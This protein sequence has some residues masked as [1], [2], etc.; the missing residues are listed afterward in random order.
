[1]HR[2]FESTF[3]SQQVVYI[4]TNNIDGLMSQYHEDAVLIFLDT[5]VCGRKHIRDFLIQN[6][7]YLTD[8]NL[9]Q[10][11]KYN[12]T[13]GIIFVQ[14]VITLHSGKRRVGY[15]LI[16]LDGK[17]SFQIVTTVADFGIAQHTSKHSIEA[18]QD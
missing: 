9:D 1:M 14:A 3:F 5:I 18:Y 17:L 4:E 6:I 7:N 8:S 10:V 15:L 2:T 13:K 12:E 11:E 16:L